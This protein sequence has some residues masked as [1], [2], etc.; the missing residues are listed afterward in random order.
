MS[1]P[2]EL[3]DLLMMPYEKQLTWLEGESKGKQTVEEIDVTIHH[4][5]A[6]SAQHTSQV[7]EAMIRVMWAYNHHAHIVRH[8]R[9]REYGF[10][11][12]DSISWTEPWKLKEPPNE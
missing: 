2:L 11:D 3:L 1:D 7:V 5:A 4:A 10:P 12:I 6:V 8:A 9:H